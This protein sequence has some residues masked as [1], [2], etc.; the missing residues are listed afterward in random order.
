MS[1]AKIPGTKFI[2]VDLGSNINTIG[3]NT[4]KEFAVRAK[5]AGL[6]TTYVSRQHRLHV[7]GVDSDAAVCDHE[8]QTPIAVKFKD[9]PAMKE[10]YRANITDGCG[11]NPPAILGLRNMT[12]KGSVLVPVREKNSSLFQ[13]LEDTKIGVVAW[14]RTVAYDTCALWTPVA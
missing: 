1:K 4:E 7:N 12:Q 10:L 13:D 14:K 11:A 5:R 9:Q 6:E 3:K 8:T 2:L